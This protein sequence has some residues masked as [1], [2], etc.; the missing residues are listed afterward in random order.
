MFDA[1]CSQFV[2]WPCLHLSLLWGFGCA[3]DSL[4]DFTGLP[5]GFAASVYARAVCTQSAAPMG[6]HSKESLCRD[7]ELT[8]SCPS[9]GGCLAAPLCRSGKSITLTGT[10]KEVGQLWGGQEKFDHGCFLL[11][12]SSI[13]FAECSLQQPCTKLWPSGSMGLHRGW[14]MLHCWSWNSCTGDGR[15]FV[16][17]TF[18]LIRDSVFRTSTYILNTAC[19]PLIP[20]W[21]SAE[22]LSARFL[23]F[24]WGTNNFGFLFPHAFAAC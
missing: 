9:S 20:D 11:F 5:Q 17:I 6:H 22:L 1:Q 13:S 3:G 8:C 2:P 16:E 14:Q 19:T 4:A 18:A 23:L 15:C 24:C 10:A 21:L 12:L 7:W